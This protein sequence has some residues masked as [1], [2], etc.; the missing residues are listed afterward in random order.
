MVELAEH[1]VYLAHQLS[2]L[3]V[4]LAQ[5]LTIWELLQQ[6]LKETQLVPLEEIIQAVEEIAPLKELMLAVLVVQVS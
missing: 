1:L 5:G 6:V 2:M 4:G 3:Q